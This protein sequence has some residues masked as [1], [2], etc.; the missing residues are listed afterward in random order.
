MQQHSDRIDES[1]IESFP[2]SDPPSWT[3]VS[4]ERTAPP[5]AG[6]QSNEVAALKQELLRAVA[7]QENIRRRAARERDDVARFANT[8]FARDVLPALDNLRRAIDSVPNDAA[9]PLTRNL[10]TGV[11]AT[12]RALLSAFSK[13][14]INR[15]SPA[16]GEPFDPNWHEAISV[17]DNRAYPPGTVVEVLQPGYRLHERLLRPAVVS[18]SGR[19]SAR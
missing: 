10:L 13:H 4:G 2:A 11:A 1:S 12:E 14:G 16:P 17:V 19:G 5:E 15:I 9:D 8:D 18:V 7:E 6:R 3:P